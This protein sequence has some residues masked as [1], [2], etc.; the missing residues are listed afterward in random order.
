MG[1]IEHQNQIKIQERYMADRVTLT[2]YGRSLRTKNLAVQITNAVPALTVVKK[3]KP[4]HH[5]KKQPGF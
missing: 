1:I 4:H 2:R 5:H 3:K